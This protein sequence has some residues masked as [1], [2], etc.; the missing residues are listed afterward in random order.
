MVSGSAEFTVEGERVEAPPGTLILAL[1]E[2][3]AQ[4]FAP[5]ALLALLKH[6]LVR[7]GDGR[8]EWLDGVRALDRAMRGPR[9]AAGLDGQ[10]VGT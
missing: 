7:S 4:R 1:V 8:L 6:P 5:L 9:P 3:A 10:G 2:A